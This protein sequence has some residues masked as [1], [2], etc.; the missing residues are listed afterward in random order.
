MKFNVK[1]LLILTLCSLLC[2]PGTLLAK[3]IRTKEE[4]VSAKARQ[5]RLN[6]LA[7]IASMSKALENYQGQYVFIGDTCHSC[8]EVDLF[9]KDPRLYKALKDKSGI[10]AV[11]FEGPGAYGNEDNQYS[12]L[13]G[14][15]SI[16]IAAQLSHVPLAD[17]TRYASAHHIFLYTPWVAAILGGFSGDRARIID[18]RRDRADT[19]K[20]M[21]EADSYRLRKEAIAQA[22]PNEPPDHAMQRLEEG[23][24][25]KEIVEN[26]VKTKPIHLG[27]E[28][29]NRIAGFAGSK[30][31][32]AIFGTAHCYGK[33]ELCSVIM[34]K[35]GMHNVRFIA[36]YANHAA[37]QKAGHDEKTDPSHYQFV[38]NAAITLDDG[39]LVYLSHTN[40]PGTGV[41]RRVA[42]DDKPAP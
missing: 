18:E 20:E 13:I 37:L 35:A 38:P 12:P 16:N 11:V 1:Q 6:V 41:Q 19:L 10:E 25:D 32:A 4:S 40:E 15:I 3:G 29:F 14:K 33:F 28:T 8:P 36:V 22:M 2:A 42:P 39:K 23:R 9:F 17:V 34:S 26:Y 5:S 24:P 21:W 30:R 7:S 31:V 27:P